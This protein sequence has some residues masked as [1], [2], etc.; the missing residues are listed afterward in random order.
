MDKRT[1]FI[2]WFT[3]FFE[4]E[5]S[6]VNDIS[7]NNK[8]RVCASQNDRAPLDEAVSIWGGSVRE[9]VRTT[10]RGKVCHGHEWRISHNASLKFIE[11][12]KP[13]MRIPSK[14]Q[15]MEE[16]I[17]KSKDGLNRRFKC[18]FCDK[19]YASPSGRRRHEKKEHIEP[20][21]LYSCNQCDASYES[22]ASLTHHIKSE[23]I[24]VNPVNPPKLVI[25]TLI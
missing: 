23:H 17:Q 24:T 13:Y 14:I 15:Q 1:E 8:L 16:A 4:G 20:G 19:D 6:V 22:R 7:N 9:R 3:G 11:D 25:Q 5:G 2:I 18:N 12:I 21:V 10:D